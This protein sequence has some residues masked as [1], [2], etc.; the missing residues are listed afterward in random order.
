MFFKVSFDLPMAKV[1]QDLEK[2]DIYLL[3]V[4]SRAEYREAHI[5]NANC[6]PVDE[7]QRHIAELPK[8]R[9]IYIYCRSGQRAQSAKKTLLACGLHQVYNVGGVLQ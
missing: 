8:D 7:L 1:K 5:A 9:P 4:R 6:I 3:D 2:E